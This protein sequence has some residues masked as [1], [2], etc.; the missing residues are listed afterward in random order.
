MALEE[1]RQAWEMRGDGTYAKVGWR[2][3]DPQDPRAL[4]LHARL[5]QAALER[6]AASREQ[7]GSP[8]A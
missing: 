1:R 6:N 5:M 2:D 7:G 8:R 3:M 4:G